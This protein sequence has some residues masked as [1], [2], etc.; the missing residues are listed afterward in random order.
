MKKHPLLILVLLLSCRMLSQNVQVE[1]K[2]P[3]NANYLQEAAESAI[4]IY[5]GSPNPC[6]QRQP[7]QRIEP[8]GSASVIGIADQS[9]NENVFHGWKFLVTAEHVVHG[10]SNI[11]LR[12]NRSDHQGVVCFPMEL[13]SSGVGPNLF[14][15]EDKTSDLA[16]IALPDIANTDPV[17]ITYSWIMDEEA[18]K[19]YEVG[20][21]TGIFTVGYLKGYA[22]ET[23]NY[24]V[25]KFGRI[26][27]LTRETWLLSD[28]GG[29]E[30]AYVVEMEGVPGLSGAPVLTYGEEIK[31]N[32][33][34]YRVLPPFLV[35][36]VK[37]SLTYSLPNTKQVMSQ[38]LTAIEPG[39]KVK[40]FMDEI[41]KKLE[42]SGAKP[43]VNFNELH[44]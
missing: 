37:D 13:R 28:R 43:V 22:G 27:V 9:A 23:H 10:H 25:T 21:G 38:G 29:Y 11:V 2:K 33:F 35:G 40:I 26:S 39:Y 30:N 32:P 17:I 31:S 7:G 19:K 34:R 42:T 14:M 18:M 4:F 20:I 1:S 5:D 36:V 16:A 44:N 8:L 12:L 6:G 3:I 24:P 15:P 41:V